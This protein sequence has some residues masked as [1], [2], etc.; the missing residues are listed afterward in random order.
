MLTVLPKG[1]TFLSVPS[2]FNSGQGLEVLNDFKEPPVL[3]GKLGPIAPAS[4]GLSHIRTGIGG[5]FNALDF[6]NSDFDT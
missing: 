4:V 2:D 5:D 1:V 6:N 3:L